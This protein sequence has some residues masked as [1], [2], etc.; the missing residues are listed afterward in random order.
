[1][2]DND[3]FARVHGIRFGKSVTSVERRPVA[4]GG[5]AH[6]ACGRE[7]P[8]GG[9]GAVDVRS[10]GFRISERFVNAGDFPTGGPGLRS[11][12]LTR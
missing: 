10:H 1:M 2:R 6:V 8:R 12:D 3:Q 5:G 11:Y 9:I 4:G 7:R